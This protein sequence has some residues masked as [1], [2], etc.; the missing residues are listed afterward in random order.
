MTRDELVVE[1]LFRNQDID[2]IKLSHL[3]A[4]ELSVNE[5][6][7]DREFTMTNVKRLGQLL[8]NYFKTR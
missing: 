3:V 7:V 5:W 1:T 8:R 2:K 4:L 6:K